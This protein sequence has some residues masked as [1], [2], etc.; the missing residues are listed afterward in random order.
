MVE[1][2]FFIL[3]EDRK[4]RSGQ[5]IRLWAKKKH[6]FDVSPLH[7][8]MPVAPVLTSSQLYYCSNYVQTQN[9]S[10]VENWARWFT[11]TD[12]GTSHV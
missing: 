12:N 8:F 11:S 3:Q 7:L 9:D 10:A 2:I 1:E 5:R 6:K 4:T